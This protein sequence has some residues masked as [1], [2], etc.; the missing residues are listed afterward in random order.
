[1]LARLKTESVV[2][3]VVRVGRY[4]N[5]SFQTAA[6]NQLACEI[7]SKGGI[8]VNVS[9]CMAGVSSPLG[10]Y[11]ETGFEA[12]K[13]TSGAFGG[14]RGIPQQLKASPL[15]V[16]YREGPGPFGATSEWC[17]VRSPQSARAR[18]RSGALNWEVIRCKYS[19]L[20]LRSHSLALFIAICPSKWAHQGRNHVA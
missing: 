10:N 12:A 9:G 1:L 4:I 2:V 18:V 8:S 20:V 3:G 11:P 15:I 16:A 6:L 7:K 14:G 17:P 5:G 19:S 13:R